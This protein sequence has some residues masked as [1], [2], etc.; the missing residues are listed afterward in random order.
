V[1]LPVAVALSHRTYVNL[2][3]SADEIKIEKRSRAIDCSF[4]HARGRIIRERARDFIPLPLL[5]S[6]SFC[7]TARFLWLSLVNQFRP[8]G[9][10]IALLARTLY[11]ATLWQS[12]ARK[13]LTRINR[14]LREKEGGGR[15]RGAISNDGRKSSRRADRAG[16]CIVSL[17][18]IYI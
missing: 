8:D 4:T 11:Q 15:T 7:A 16:F 10:A 1:V 5:S 17:N 9:S 6:A 14:G 12:A 18:R 13:F 3:K 2:V